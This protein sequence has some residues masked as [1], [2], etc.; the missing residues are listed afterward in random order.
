MKVK[1]QHKAIKAAGVHRASPP[2]NFR[3]YWC[4]TEMEYVRHAEFSPL[5]LELLKKPLKNYVLN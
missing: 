2:Q 5:L 3:L 4:E 1:N